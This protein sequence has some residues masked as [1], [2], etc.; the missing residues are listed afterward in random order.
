[1]KVDVFLG[2]HP[3]FYDMEAKY[4]KVTAGGPNPFIDPE[5]LKKYVDQKE[6]EFNKMLAAQQQ[7]K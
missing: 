1:M 7:G 5:G 4:A 6:A 2:A 3:N